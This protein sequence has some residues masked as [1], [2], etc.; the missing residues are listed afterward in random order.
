MKMHIAG[1]WIDT[2]KKI[3]VLNPYNEEVV[4]TVPNAAPQEVEKA[5]ASGARGAEVMAE[6]P[7]YERSSILMKA[8]GLL[9]EQQEEFARLISKES[10]KA[11][12]ESRFE[13][14]RS[15]ET[16]ELSAEEAKRIRGSSACC[17]D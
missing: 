14:V 13:V 10:G 4:D 8:A 5:L 16:I 15:A 6:L 7:A 12:W 3:E 11:L 17:R 1:E 2:E 9:R